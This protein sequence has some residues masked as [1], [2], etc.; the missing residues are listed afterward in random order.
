MRIKGLRT[1]N[2][3]PL[4][5]WCLTITEQL[6][7]RRQ[8]NSSR[9]RHNL[10]DGLC[11][12]LLEDRRLLAVDRSAAFAEISIEGRAY[13]ASHLLVRFDDTVENV[14]EYLQS[15]TDSALH[16]AESTAAMPFVSGLHKVG[17]GSGFSFDAAMNALQLDPHVLYVE[18]DYIIYADELATDPRFSDQWDF[19]NIGQTGGKFDADMD[20][21][22]AWEATTGTGST[23]VAVIDTGIDYLHPDLAA[24]IWT[25][26]DEIAGNG[27]DDDQNGYI[28]D[29]HG[30]DFHHD[31]GDQLACRRNDRRCGKQRD[32]HCRCQLERAVDAAENS[33]CRRVGNDQ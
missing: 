12:E 25:N 8:R 3:R 2:M 21:P 13:D 30:Y 9:R 15:A 23:I 10:V 22:E 29:V 1:A 32:R 24:N 16:S 31:A 33:W 26:E 4:L 27:I 17:F 19:H 11:G 18:P 14:V 5:H 6:N 28:D 7:H 20:A